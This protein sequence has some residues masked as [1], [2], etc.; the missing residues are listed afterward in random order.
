[1]VVFKRLSG[2][3]V[4]AH[5]SLTLY[6]TPLKLLLDRLTCRGLPRGLGNSQSYDR[7]IFHVDDPWAEWKR[8]PR[9]D[10]KWWWKRRSQKLRLFPGRKFGRGKHKESK[11]L[12]ASSSKSGE[13]QKKVSNISLSE[14][15]LEEV[16]GLLEEKGEELDRTIKKKRDWNF[17]RQKQSWEEPCWQM[18]TNTYWVNELTGDFFDEFIEIITEIFFL[19]E[20]QLQTKKLP[21]PMRGER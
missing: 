6:V 7:D 12:K 19:P 3:R 18:K 8:C 15:D 10:R 1:M 17:I 16:R 2:K 20:C 4:Y 9:W 21:R 13:K 11:R 14:E 5:T